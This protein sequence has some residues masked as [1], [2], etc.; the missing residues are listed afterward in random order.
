[1]NVLKP[2]PYI[3]IRKCVNNKISLRKIISLLLRTGPHTRRS[4]QK[5]N[6]H[7]LL[8][9]RPSCG[10][11]VKKSITSYLEYNLLVQHHSSNHL[12]TRHLKWINSY[13]INSGIF[14]LHFYKS[15]K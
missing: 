11:L 12:P 15:K 14:S 4:I 9:R 5:F 7:T 3:C 8:S 2:F 6:F 1:M 13:S 10:A